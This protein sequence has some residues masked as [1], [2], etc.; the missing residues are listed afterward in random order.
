MPSGLRPGFLLEHQFKGIGSVKVKFA[1]GRLGRYLDGTT[2]RRRL[3]RPGLDYTVTLILL[4]TTAALAGIVRVDD[5]F[6]LIGNAPLGIVGNVLGDIGGLSR[7][8]GV[9][10]V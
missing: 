7:L 9:P 1:V 6:R 3:R 4:A 10:Q 8:V 2:A 5:T